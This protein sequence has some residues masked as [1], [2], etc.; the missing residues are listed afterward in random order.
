MCLGRTATTVRIAQWL[1][2]WS[3]EER[4]RRE[5]KTVHGALALLRQTHEDLVRNI[6]A[7]RRRVADYDRDI[8]EIGLRWRARRGHVAQGALSAGD[9]AAVQHLLR[10][11]RLVERRVQRFYGLLDT[12]AQQ[13]A[14]LEDSGLLTASLTA[15]RTGVAAGDAM[16]MQAKDVEDILDRV[17]EQQALLADTQQLLLDQ[18]AVNETVDEATLEDELAALMSSE[19]FTQQFSEEHVA[20]AERALAEAPDVPSATDQQLA[21][22][23][24]M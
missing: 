22:A 3:P 16:L 9:K 5:R 8:M 2:Y 10:Q 23:E 4:L 1:W 7:K 6:A 14:A 19:S 24:F 11:K 20:E 12:V 17:A 18:Q 15:M 21:Q 13:I